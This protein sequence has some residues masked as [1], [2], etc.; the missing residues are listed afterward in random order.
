RSA[1][2][3]GGDFRRRSLSFA[4]FDA[5]LKRAGCAIHVSGRHLC[6][7]C[8]A[9][10]AIL[11]AHFAGSL[12][13]G[14]RWTTCRAWSRST[15][16]PRREVWPLRDVYASIF[17]DRRGP[18]LCRERWRLPEVAPWSVAFSRWVSSPRSG[19]AKAVRAV[20]RP[21]SYESVAARVRRREPP[22]APEPL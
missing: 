4:T 15:H 6:R 7:G 3:A 13:C 21:P 20:L 5:A 22:A 11:P 10:G 9:A 18:L 8:L 2:R 19:R 1:R 17:P 12:G 16:R 14:S